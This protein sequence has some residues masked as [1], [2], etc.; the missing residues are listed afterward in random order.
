[1]IS[2]T[3]HRIVLFL[4]LIIL[5]VET[6]LVSTASIGL[7]LVIYTIL[8]YLILLFVGSYFLELEYYMPVKK[9]LNNKKEIALTF[10]DG[11]N[12][13]ITPQLLEV[14][15]TH[16]I[17]VNF[18]CIGEKLEDQKELVNQMIQ[19]GHLI[20]NHSY[21]HSNF[22][23][24]KSVKAMTE[25]LRQTNRIIKELTKIENL[26]FRP[27]FGVSNP[28]VAKTVRKLGMQVIGWNLRSYDTVIKG[29]KLF[30]RLVQKTKGGDIVLLHDNHQDIVDVVE[31][32]VVY[33][34]KNGF[35]FVKL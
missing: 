13:E 4:F 7:S 15:K 16:G 11:P 17:Q 8:S 20:A 24:L 25:E 34:K 9:D 30:K 18:F 2:W 27:P 19:E 28:L 22:F 3:K 5:I 12:P 33:A 29:E 26:Y 23:P 6:Y 35:T 10:D 21:T 32:Y 14:F 31:R 1:M